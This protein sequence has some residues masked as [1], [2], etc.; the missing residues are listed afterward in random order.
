MVG[1][2]L[3]RSCFGVTA[4]SA[5]LPLRLCTSVRFSA[6]R[7]VLFGCA[8]GYALR[9]TLRLDNVVLRC[10]RMMYSGTAVDVSTGVRRK[11][12][13]ARLFA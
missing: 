11:M 8:L 12:Q 10:D 5:W 9:F 13:L 6:V 3:R 4:A 7:G 2:Q 1:N